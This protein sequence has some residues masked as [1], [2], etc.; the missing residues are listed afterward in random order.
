[1]IIR[2]IPRT[3]L[4]LLGIAVVVSIFAMAQP[5][6]AQC[7]KMSDAEIVANIYG[8]INADSGLAS[9]VSHI[10]VVGTAELSAVKLQGWANSQSDYEKVRQFGLDLKCKVNENQF[11]A[12][13]PA[14]DS[15]QRAAGGCATGTKACG[16]VCI[17]DGDPCN[18]KAGAKA[19]IFPMFRFD[20]DASL[21][22]LAP[23]STCGLN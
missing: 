17:P 9:Q 15:Q 4:M 6:I 2:S 16:D 7:E 20:F 21:A 3:G 19:S 10:N 23:M 12:A 18:I 14:A 5:A 13:P 8:R 22:F 1:M 11:A